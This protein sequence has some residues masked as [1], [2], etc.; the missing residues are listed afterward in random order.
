MGVPGIEPASE[1][2]WF[3]TL[4]DWDDRRLRIPPSW[5]CPQVLKCTVARL[6]SFVLVGWAANPQEDLRK[7]DNEQV[8]NLI[9]YHYHGHS[10]VSTINPDCPPRLHTK[11]RNVMWC[12]FLHCDSISKVYAYIYNAGKVY[13]LSSHLVSGKEL[14]KR[15]SWQIFWIIFVRR[16]SYTRWKCVRAKNTME[17][18]ENFSDLRHTQ[19]QLYY[20]FNNTKGYKTT[21]KILQHH[22]RFWNNDT[23]IQ[24]YCV[25]NNTKGSETT[26]KVLKQWHTNTALTPAKPSQSSFFKTASCMV[27]T[28]EEL[29]WLR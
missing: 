26:P 4:L 21:L 15:S 16:D 28:D 10:T 7:R 22:Q 3:I 23:Q 5:V 20:M 13:I 18:N 24:L 17:S 2:E 19:F 27:T 1:G 9:H 25:L 11:W 14:D 6:L 12:V 29:D 8:Y